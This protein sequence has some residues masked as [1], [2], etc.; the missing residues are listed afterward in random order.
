MVFWIVGRWFLK[1]LDSDD[2]P[3]FLL[4]VF[5]RVGFG[6]LG[7]DQVAWIT[8]LSDTKMQSNSCV[9]RSVSFN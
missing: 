9:H 6:F 8:S 7:L 2:F 1:G 5:R 4:S 3:G